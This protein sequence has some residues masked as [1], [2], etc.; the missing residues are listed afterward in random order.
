MQ[1]QTAVDNC[2]QAAELVDLDVTMLFY[3]RV[4][5]LGTL[6]NFK[7]FAKLKLHQYLG[8]VACR[9]AYAFDNPVP[10]NH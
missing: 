5:I 4:L 2:Q 8:G 3:K 7:T 10:Q 9:R 6:A 1:C